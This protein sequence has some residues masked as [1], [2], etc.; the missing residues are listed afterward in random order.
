MAKN[1]KPYEVPLDDDL[2]QEILNIP[3]EPVE[4][5]APRTIGERVQQAIMAVEEANQYLAKS[6]LAAL[7]AD[8]VMR[9]LKKRGTPSIRV[10]ADGTV[11]LRVAYD[12]EREALAPAPVAR[13][14]KKSDLP[15]MDELR[16][17]A[18]AVGVDVSHLGRQRRA[19]WEL[20]KAAEEAAAEDD[21]VSPPD[22]LVDELADGPPTPP[23][24]E[25]PKTV[26]R[27]KA[28]KKAK[29][30]NGPAT[31]APPADGADDDFDID[32]LIDAETGT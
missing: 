15:T 6:P 17:R 22:R 30:D 7:V 26:R 23:S 4:S 21:E 11:I 9:R 31:K 20:V 12:E 13:K 2:A 18:E 16:K 32:D 8:T 3:V 14:T 25:R 24:P 10:Q 27:K 29:G 5:A 1:V 28:D 19:I